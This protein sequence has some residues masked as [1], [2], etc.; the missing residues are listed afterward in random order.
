[1]PSK[2]FFNNQ[3]YPNFMSGTWK[4]ILLIVGLAVLAGLIGFGLYKF[5]FAAPVPTTT[6]PVGGATTT[7][8]QLPG[9]GQRQPGE[10]GATTTAGQLPGAGAVAEAP[11][12]GYYQPQ[13]VNK[14]TSDFTTFTS[15]NSVNG[16]LRYYNAADGKFYRVLADGTVSKLSDQVFYNASNVTWAKNQDKAVIEYPDSS[17][18]MYNF[19]TQKQ[20]TLPKHWEDFSFSADGAQIAAKSVGL[21]PENRWLVTAKDDGTGTKLIE[22][23]GENQDKVIV[24]WSPSQQTAAFSKTGQAMGTDRQEIYLVGLNHENFKS[25][26]VEGL[27]FE[28]QWSP[29]GKKLL[30]SVYSSRSNYNPELWITGAYGDDIG[31]GRRM[32]KVNTWADKCAFANDDTIYCAV[33]RDLPQG[34]GMSPA[35]ASDAFYDMYKIDLKTGLKTGVNLG[36]D[37]RV[38]NVSYDSSGGRL[39]FTDAIQNGVFEVKL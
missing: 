30:Y 19:S 33:P 18:I 4:R 35:V 38:G 25:L 21:S 17:K 2:K 29:T 24:D 1:M 6:L 20:Y 7:A 10:Q 8:G 5:F 15:L 39:L 31:S 14:L 3:I 27:G 13:P 16:G 26:V 37:Y 12:A 32:L 28:P 34:A 9:A 22:S 11:G 36:G 23:L